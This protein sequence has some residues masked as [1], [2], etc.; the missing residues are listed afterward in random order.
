M[1][2]HDTLLI[3]L[4]RDIISSTLGIIYKKSTLC[5]LIVRSESNNVLNVLPRLNLQHT[6]LAKQRQISANSPHIHYSSSISL[7][8]LFCVCVCVCVFIVSHVPEKL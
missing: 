7:L 8:C 3:R 2:I 1:E 6:I 5:P 4:S